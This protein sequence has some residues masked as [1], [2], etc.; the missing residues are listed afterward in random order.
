M[1]LFG[2][3]LTALAISGVMMSGS[4][5]AQQFPKD[6]PIM[7][8]VPY[9]PGGN[10]DTTARL[11]APAMSEILGQQVVVENRAGAGGFI[12]SGKVARA[13][14]DGHTLLLGSSGTISI[15][16]AISQNPPYDPIKDLVAVGSIHAVPLVLSGSARGDIKTYDQFLSKAKADPGSVSIASA[17]NGSTQHLAIELIAMKTGTK[18]NHIPY[19]G[20]GPA[21][22]D[23]VGAQVQT[24]VD[25]MTSSLPFITKGV[26]IPMAVTSKKR[27]PKLPN[28]PTLQELGVKDVDMKTYTGVFAPAGTP[29]AVVAKIK[30]A[31]VKALHRKDVRDKFES[32]GVEMLDM[33]QAEFQAFVKSDYENSRAIGKAANVSIK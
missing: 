32:L 10:V 18:L 20:S 1:K 15:G 13:T 16:P 17:G 3:T 12:G 24:M 6:Q 4:A 2:K 28:V 8:V 21:L 33:N 29:P 23:L 19:K 9:A 27:S 7:L 26:I 22:S 31:L 14:P 30:D 25:Q 5:V 11:V